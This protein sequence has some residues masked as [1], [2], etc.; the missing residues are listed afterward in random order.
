MLG[1]RKRKHEDWFDEKNTSISPLL[2]AVRTCRQQVLSGR[3]TRSITTKLRA[4][5]AKVQAATRD[6]K[7][8]WWLRKAEEQQSFADTNNTKVFYD[9]LKEIYGPTQCGTNPVLSADSE[10]LYT[11]PE[12]ILRRWKDHFQTLLNQPSC[13]DDE[14]IDRIKSRPITAS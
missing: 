13:P 8:N 5:K 9:C 2:T 12:D 1:F 6:M 7:T 10:Q 11:S 3:A 14:A 4:V